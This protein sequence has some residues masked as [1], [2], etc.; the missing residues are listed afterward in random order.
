[1]T[2]W[3]FEPDWSIQLWGDASVTTPSDPSPQTPLYTDGSLAS[4]ARLEYTYGYGTYQGAKIDC[5]QNCL[6]SVKSHHCHRSNFNIRVCKRKLSE[7]REEAT[8]GDWQHKATAFLTK[9]RL[10]TGGVQG[11]KIHSGVLWTLRIP[12][13]WLLLKSNVG[14]FLVLKLQGCQVT[15]V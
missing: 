2:P 12:K 14:K 3:K 5:P 1:M 10:G 11:N 8:D 6:Q 13:M 15:M 7:F 9:T 4:L